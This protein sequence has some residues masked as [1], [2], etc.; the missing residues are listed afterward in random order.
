MPGVQ[1]CALPISE[2]L[3]A[4]AETIDLVV[5]REAQ[6]LGT[7]TGTA[8]LQ[9]MNIDRLQ[10]RLQDLIL[11]GNSYGGALAL[12]LICT[13]WEQAPQIRG[14]VLEDAA[15]YPQPTPPYLDLLSRSPGALL[16][17]PRIESWLGRTGLLQRAARQMLRHVASDPTRVPA[18]PG[19]A[20]LAAE[21]GGALG[22][23]ERLL[24]CG[25]WCCVGGAR[26]G[27]GGLR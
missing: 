23:V 13:P 20:G 11:V 16:S 9:V 8:L 19:A 24:G 6:F 7:V 2:P 21:P 27:G 1:T 18:N 26:I 22:P 4:N 5:Q 12:R 14:L 3:R 17:H 25:R 15:G 10:Q